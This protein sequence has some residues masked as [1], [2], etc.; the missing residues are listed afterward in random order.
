MGFNITEWLADVKLKGDST[1]L[2]THR[3]EL[4]K[5]R[6]DILKLNK[7]KICCIPTGVFEKSL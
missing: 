6:S 1:Q 3:P 2:Q 4:A 7:H 5:N